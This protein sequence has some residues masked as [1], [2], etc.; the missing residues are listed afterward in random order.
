M[1]IRPLLP[2][3][4]A[5]CLLTLSAPAH[6]QSFAVSADLPLQ[7]DANQG[8][9]FGRDELG[10]AVLGFNLGA[11]GVGATVVDFKQLAAARARIALLDVFWDAPVP[12]VNLRVGGGVGE[13]RYQV[14]APS[15]LPETK[16]TASEVFVHVGYPILPLL[17]VH[18]GYHLIQADQDVVDMS[19]KLLTL[20]VRVGW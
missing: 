18:L 1:R 11:L 14:T 17:D 2:V 4:I 10:G 5:I 15:Q 16:Q 3:L 7:Y 8:D 19:G 12:V 6:A 13:S 20:G 9:T